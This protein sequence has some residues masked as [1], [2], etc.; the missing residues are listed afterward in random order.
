MN[1]GQEHLQFSSKDS[2]FKIIK[3]RRSMVL[4][5]RFKVSYFLSGKKKINDI[6]ECENYCELASEISL[7]FNEGKDSDHKSSK[8]LDLDNYLY[9]LEEKA[10][11]TLDIALIKT[12][13]NLTESDVKEITEYFQKKVPFFS[14]VKFL[15]VYCMKPDG[16]EFNE[17]KIVRNKDNK[18]YS[19]KVKLLPVKS[20]SLSQ[21]KVED[22]FSM[23]YLYQ[24]INDSWKT[25]YSASYVRDNRKDSKNIKGVAL[26]DIPIDS[27]NVLLGKT[28]LFTDYVG[29]KSVLN[30]TIDSV[31]EI[32]GKNKIKIPISYYKEAYSF[33][34]PLMEEL[35]SWE[36]QGKYKHLAPFI[37]RANILYKGKDKYYIGYDQNRFKG[38]GGIMPYVPHTVPGSGIYGSL[39]PISKTNSVKIYSENAAYLHTAKTLWPYIPYRMY[40]SPKWTEFKLVIETLINGDFNLKTK[41]EYVTGNNFQ[42]EF[43]GFYNVFL[44]YVS[45]RYK[46]EMP[47]NSV[48]LN[49]DYD[50]TTTTT[51]I[52]GGQNSNTTT[53]DLSITIEPRFEKKLKEYISQ[54]Y[55]SWGY[56]RNYKE[57]LD[58]FFKHIKSY[59]D[60]ILQQ[61]L[62]NTFRFANDLEAKKWVPKVNKIKKRYN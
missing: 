28:F 61:L 40:I 62:E 4:P 7:F 21:D 2:I 54:L 13:V 29:N 15:N 37:K 45:S 42:G 39:A 36:I 43:E 27:K 20:E 11:L 23:T 17:Y 16:S 52:L 3:S 22:T 19:E 9:N 47:E 8:K 14:V 44:W 48:T 41:D 35:V 55:F 59:N 5:S 56:S 30:F 34:D 32:S 50:V 25:A 26:Y 18:F 51:S 57:T 53:S 1:Y 38:A 31:T 33:L 46:T 6:V 49:Y 24:D 58:Y 60:P 12:N 10:S